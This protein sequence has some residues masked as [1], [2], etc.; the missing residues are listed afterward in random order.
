MEAK[1]EL[2]GR[3]KELT[4]HHFIPKTLHT[5][6]LFK[7]LYTTDFM[8]SSGINLCEDCHSN[9]HKFF[10]EK[11]LGREYNDKKKL[12]SDERVRKFLRWVKKQD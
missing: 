10:T 2:C 7:K 8:K 3:I 4:F 1:C 11:E 5:N 6:K 12:L 9:I